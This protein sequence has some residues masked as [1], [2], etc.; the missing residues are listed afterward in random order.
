MKNLNR[1]VFIIKRN[2]MNECKSILLDLFKHILQEKG[3]SIQF[4]IYL[5]RLSLYYQN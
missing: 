5:Q 2:N 1:K 3:V 4:Q